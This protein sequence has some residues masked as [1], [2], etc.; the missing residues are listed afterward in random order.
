MVDGYE[1]LRRDDLHFIYKI[2]E[3][4][5]AL[6]IAINKKDL[7]E[8]PLGDYEKL[9]KER[10]MISEYI[11]VVYMSAKTGKGVED[12]LLAAK[13]VYSN[14]GMRITTSRLNSFIKEIKNSYP[15]M[16]K[17]R[18]M[19][20]I[21]YATQAEV[22]PPAIVFTVNCPELLRKSFF[23]FLERKLREKFGFLGAPI[24]LIFKGRDE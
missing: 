12:A 23:N 24:R 14:L 20:K 11:P 3:A 9:V 4:K 7:I 19:F 2:W 18:K 10:L 8:K 1:G 17:G 22:Y 21:Y 6:V 16:T 13:S 5:K 15:K